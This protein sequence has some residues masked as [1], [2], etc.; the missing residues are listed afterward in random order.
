M[1]LSQRYNLQIEPIYLK[2]KI[3]EK[4]WEEIPISFSLLEK[5]IMI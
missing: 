1:Q 4:I 5:I 3:D 2:Y